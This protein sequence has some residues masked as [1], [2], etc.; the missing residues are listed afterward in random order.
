MSRNCSISYW[1]DVTISAISDTPVLISADDSIDAKAVGAWIHARSP[2]RTG[3]LI[4]LDARRL[5]PDVRFEHFEPARARFTRL[6]TVAP[7]AGGTLLLTHL[8]AMPLGTQT[9]LCG[10]LDR[11]TTIDPPM[12]RVVATTD[13]LVH[14]RV[15]AGQIREELFYRLN[16][17]HIVLSDSMT[18]AE[19]QIHADVAL[20]DRVTR[21]SAQ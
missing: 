4:V 21:S 11:R 2:R 8:E 13:R 16:V 18:S 5:Q 1:E 9:R 6:R 12:L 14:A 20:R 19:R 3:R 15:R 10:F 17:I 7:P